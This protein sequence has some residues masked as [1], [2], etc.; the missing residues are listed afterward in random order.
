VKK[1]K[2]AV[3]PRNQRNEAAFN[4]AKTIQSMKKSESRSNEGTHSPMLNYF[5]MKETNMLLFG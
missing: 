5:Q 2:A 3:V 4:L 1:R